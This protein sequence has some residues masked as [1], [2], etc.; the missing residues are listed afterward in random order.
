[1]ADIVQLKEDGVAKYLK[2]HAKA[3]DGVDGALVKAT[4][5]ETILGTKNFRDG[6]QV[7]GKNVL[8]A[9]FI[10]TLGDDNRIDE[11]VTYLVGHLVRQGNIVTVQG[12]FKSKINGAVNIF[13][14]PE[15]FRC[16]TYNMD[17]LPMDGINANDES[18]IAFYNVATNHNVKASGN[19]G[20]TYFHG[21]WYTTDSYPS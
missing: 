16:T 19:V 21:S 10:K 7:A 11:N 15:G 17:K 13:R 14:V 6:L 5:N 9:P 2:T 20:N 1:M 3:I 12:Y 8:Y 4:G 18:V